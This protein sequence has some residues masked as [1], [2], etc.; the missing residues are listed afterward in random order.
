DEALKEELAADEPSVIIS[1]R[2]CALLKYVK[3]NKPVVID[4]NKCVGCKSCMKIG[5]PA[6]SMVDGKA[7]IDNTLCT[8]CGVCAQLCK[9][10]AI[11]AAKED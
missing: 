2:P 6:I 9:L 8:G 7:T 1:R 5:C 3:H 11:S 10:G 4:P